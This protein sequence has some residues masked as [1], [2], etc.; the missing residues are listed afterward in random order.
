MVEM[1]YSHWLW[2][3]SGCCVA[4]VCVKTLS[5]MEV[6]ARV[7]LV[8]LVVAAVWYD[9]KHFVQPN[10]KFPS[11]V[12]H[13]HP[14]PPP[15]HTH[16]N[17][18]AFKGCLSL[19]GPA[20]WW[21]SPVSPCCH[22]ADRE[23]HPAVWVSAM[24]PWSL[25]HTSAHSPSTSYQVPLSLSVSVCLSLTPPLSPSPQPSLLSLPDLCVVSLSFLPRLVHSGSARSAPAQG[26]ELV[27]ATRTGTGR[28][29]ESHVFRVETTWDLSSWTRALVQGGHAAAEL[30]KEVSIG[31]YVCVNSFSVHGMLVR[32]EFLFFVFWECLWFVVPCPKVAFS[33]LSRKLGQNNRVPEKIRS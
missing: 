3:V 25:V 29:I 32:I 1:L 10:Q 24:E 21:P 8:Y 27:F 15:T 12:V 28:G 4:A 16:E 33:P 11:T 20:G 14:L 31:E 5:C 23:R 9:R 18:H 30:I 13:A 2:S 22:G 6:C 26:A 7:C 19:I 17:T